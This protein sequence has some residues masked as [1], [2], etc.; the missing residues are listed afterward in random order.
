MAK[1]ILFMNLYFGGATNLIVLM[2]KTFMIYMISVLIGVAFPRFRVEQSIRFFLG[3]PTLIGVIAIA[4][5]A[6]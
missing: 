4:I 3:W 2:I 1:L 5:M 6:L